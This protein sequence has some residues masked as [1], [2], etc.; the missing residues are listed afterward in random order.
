MEAK[1]VQI[2]FD[3]SSLQGNRNLARVRCCCHFVFIWHVFLKLSKWIW[4]PTKPTR[5]FPRVLP[6]WLITLDSTL[7]CRQGTLYKAPRSS[8]RKLQDDNVWTKSDYWN[9]LVCPPSVPLATS[10][11][12]DIR[13]FFICQVARFSRKGA[14]FPPPLP[15][16]FL[17]LACKCSGLGLGPNRENARRECQRESQK[18]CQ[19]RCQAL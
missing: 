18:E 9:L 13:C 16:L 3:T 8:E 10:K 17:L 15:F 7:G 11:P 19:N 5:T 4:K 2:M 14:K 12:A 6:A 1:L